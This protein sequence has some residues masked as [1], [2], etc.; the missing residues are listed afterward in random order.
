M[1]SVKKMEVQTAESQDALE[2]LKALREE[3]ARLIAE[4]QALQNKAKAVTF[5]VVEFRD[6]KTGELKRGINIHGI[7]AKPMFVYGS[8][9][10]KLVEVC[11]SLEDFVEANRATLSWKS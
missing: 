8:Q 7:T 2:Q 9:A 3:N 11:G 6:K 4:A 5:K 10:L 1:E